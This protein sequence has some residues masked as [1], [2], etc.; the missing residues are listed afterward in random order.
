MQA[1]QLECYEFLDLSDVDVRERDQLATTLYAR[2]DESEEHE[3]GHVEQNEAGLHEDEE[4]NRSHSTQG[5]EQEANYWRNQQRGRVA[6]NNNSNIVH[7][8]GRGGGFGSKGGHQNQHLVFVGHTEQEEHSNHNNSSDSRPVSRTESVLTDISSSYLSS[9]A[10]SLHVLNS[11]NNAHQYPASVT[12]P[13]LLINAAACNGALTHHANTN[14]YGE[15][16][17]NLLLLIGIR[18][19]GICLLL[20]RI[21]GHRWYFFYHFVVYSITLIIRMFIYQADQKF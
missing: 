4:L 21:R 6:Y 20:N 17:G 15:W 3:D 16:R 18:I 14:S 1:E 9:S 7:R 2:D 19:W 8:K 5:E 12:S 11:N 13:P 10:S